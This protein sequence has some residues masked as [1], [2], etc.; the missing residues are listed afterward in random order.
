MLLACSKQRICSHQA[1]T[2]TTTT[3]VSPEGTQDGERLA[4]CLLSCPPSLQLAPKDAP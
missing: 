3:T 4:A 2:T 1:T